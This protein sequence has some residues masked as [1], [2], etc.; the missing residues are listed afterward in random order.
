MCGAER[1]PS[2][3][4]NDASERN[5]DGACVLLAPDIQEEILLAEAGPGFQPINE[6][7]LRWVVCARDWPTQRRR[8]RDLNDV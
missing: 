8:W 7:A 5:A 1:K 2:L 4:D 3:E 6:R